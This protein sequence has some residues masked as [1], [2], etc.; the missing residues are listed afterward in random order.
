MVLRH[1][2]FTFVTFKYYWRMKLIGHVAGMGDIINAYIIL[3]R[4]PERKRPL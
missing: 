1:R 2:D 3:A 4:K